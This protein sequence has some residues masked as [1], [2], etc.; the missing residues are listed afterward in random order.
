MLAALFTKVL[1][2]INYEDDFAIYEFIP[3]IY[4]RYLQF[5]ES[6]YFSTFN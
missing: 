1:L 2:P 5:Y 4:D 3:I 6:P